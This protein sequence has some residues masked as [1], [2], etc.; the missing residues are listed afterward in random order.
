MFNGHVHTTELYDVDGV[1]VCGRTSRRRMSAA[2]CRTRNPPNPSGRLPEQSG[3]GPADRQR[4]PLAAGLISRQTAHAQP[5]AHRARCALAS[6]FASVP[7]PGRAASGGPLIPRT[8]CRLCS[9]RANCPYEV[10]NP[11]LS[12]VVTANGLSIVIVRLAMRSTRS[13][14]SRSIEGTETVEFPSSMST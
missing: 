1:K 5:W 14:V 10:R 4:L 12:G 7:P 6:I 11:Q 3:P 13:V 9:W 2:R 8:A